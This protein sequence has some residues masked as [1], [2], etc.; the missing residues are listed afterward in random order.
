MNTAQTGRRMANS[1]RL[2][3]A[4][5]L[6]GDLDGA[7]WPYTPSVAREL[8]ELI[9]ALRHRL[10]Q[11]ID[12]S[13]NWSSLQ[14]APDL[15]SLNRRGMAA[16]VGREIRR[17]RLMTIT[18]RKARANLLVVPCRTSAALAVMVLR[19]AAALPVA[20]AQQETE[21]FRAADAIVRAVRAESAQSATLANSS[22]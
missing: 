7:W 10:G 12:I 13:V 16:I 20:P 6:G 21:S 4:S 15:D 19:Q 5:E 3:L 11:I 18:G 22:A 9:D 8:P 14:G 1:V 2:T 17:Q